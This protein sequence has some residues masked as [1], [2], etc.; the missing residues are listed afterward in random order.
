VR[1]RLE[2]LIGEVC[3]VNSLCCPVLRIGVCI[4]WLSVWYGGNLVLDV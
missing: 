4:G 2:A 3:L 1:Y